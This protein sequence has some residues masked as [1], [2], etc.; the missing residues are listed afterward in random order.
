[1]ALFAIGG[2]LLS[3]CIALRLGPAWLMGGGW[4]Q[5]PWRLFAGSPASWS[6]AW[7]AAVFFALSAVILLAAACRPAIE[8]HETHLRIG[9]RDI[10]WSHI[11]RLDQTGWNVPLAVY[12]TLKD[13]AL[14]DAALKDEAL[15]DEA[16]KDKVRLLVIYPGDFDSSASLL[17]YLRRYAREALLDGIPYRQFWGE[18][19]A[20][21]R[22][23]LPLP[24]YPLLRPED[25]EEVERLFQ[26]LKTVGHLE[27]RNPDE[28]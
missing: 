17:R 2:T 8:I 27:R 15:R 12:L 25:E 14:K 9:R 23:Q 18:P 11:V 6:P 1:M 20:N 21:E 5:T 19:A 4:N 24:R 7:I 22:K 28:K 3:V 26:R 16:L 13:E 10:A